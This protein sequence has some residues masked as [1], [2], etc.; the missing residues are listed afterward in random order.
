MYS[1]HLWNTAAKRRII[2]NDQP[3]SRFKDHTCGPK[4]EILRTH[5]TVNIAVNIRFKS[6]RTSENSR[7]APWNWKRKILTVLIS[8]YICLEMLPCT[9]E[10]ECWGWWEA[11]WSFQMVE[12]L[13]ASR[14]D[15]SLRSESQ[16]RTLLGVWFELRTWCKISEKIYRVS[17]V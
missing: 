13:P 17:I 10:V 14:C 4:E 2:W 12:T 16:E 11:W 5:S 15:I 8:N 3:Y 9:L 6:A 7:G 1:R